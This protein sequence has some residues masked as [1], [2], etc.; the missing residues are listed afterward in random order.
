MRLTVLFDDMEQVLCHWNSSGIFLVELSI[1]IGSQFMPAYAEQ[2]C[3]S[4]PDADIRIFTGP[5]SILEDK[6]IANPTGP[7]PYGKSCIPGSSDRRT[8]Y[9][10]LSH[11]HLPC[12]GTVLSRICILFRGIAASEIS[13]EGTRKRRQRSC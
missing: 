4:H 6:L 8:L 13:P 12:Q 9:G 7:G 1:T 11:H 5:S 3:S 10:R 2:F